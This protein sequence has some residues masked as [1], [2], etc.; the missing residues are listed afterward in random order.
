MT[1]EQ[2]LHETVAHL[3]AIERPPCS[4]GERDAAQWIAERLREH[5]CDVTVEPERVHGTFHWLLLALA[6][7][8]GAGGL[9]ALRGRRDVG[10]VAGALAAA[11]MW[12]DLRGGR[13]RWFRRR[14][15]PQGTTHNVVAHTGDRGARRTLVV[16]AHHD[17]ARTSFIFDQAGVRAL[18]TRAPWL[19]SRLDR[20]PP[21][22]WI[23]VAGPGLFAWGCLRGRRGT[24]G[25]GTAICAGTV[26]VMADLGTNAV[27]PAAN[28]NATAVAVL[29]ELARE[30][31]AEPVEGL[32]V[33]LLSAGAEEANQE[34]IIA[35][36][37]RH[38]DAL[39]PEHTSFLCLDT[40]GSPEL[41]M[42]E[43]E[44]FLVMRDYPR[45][46]KDRVQ[47]AADAAGV[48]MRRGLRL[49]FATD[50]LIPMRAG[51]PTAS[52]GSVNEYLMPSNYHWPTDTADRVD[53]G[54]VAAAL[55][56]T[57]RLIDDLATA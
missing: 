39:A 16:L 22:M 50:A 12:E 9:A 41:T 18:A 36:A 57:R 52:I 4:P 30:L 51:Y 55:R 49:S 10:A 8:A 3:A 53:Y 48:H 2:R 7:I 21:L 28:D 1:V 43:G 5:G 33:L 20:W 27:V 45:A 35:F 32:R 46:F 26:A 25:A 11:S 47:A 42:L 37:R 38:F 23:V 29:V 34:G 24:V 40:I 17:A 6:G 54:T 19:L 31:E 56:M 13:R 44:G 15:M 14:V